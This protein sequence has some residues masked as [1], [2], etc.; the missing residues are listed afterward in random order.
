[1]PTFGSLFAGIGGLDLG[2]ERAGF[3]CRWQVEFDPTCTQVLS[4]H[5]PDVKRFGDVTQVRGEDLEPVDLIVGGWPCQD[6]SLAGRRAGLAGRRSGL[7]FEFMRLVDELSPEWILAENVPGLLSAGCKPKCPGGCVRT[8][9]GAMGSVIGSLADRGYGYAWR[10]LDAQYLGLAQR[11]KRVF[12]VGHLGTPWSGPAQ[13]LFEPESL[14]GDPPSRSASGSQ[15]AAGTA[16]SARGDDRSV[17]EPIVPPVSGTLGG[18]S[19]NRGWSDDLD[20]AGAFVGYPDP[21]HAL[22]APAHGLRYDFES[23]S[24]AYSVYPES[25]QGADLRAVEIQVAPTLTGT[26]EAEATDRGTR[27]VQGLVRRLTPVECERLQGF[28]DGWTATGASGKAISDSKRYK[29][30]G[31]AVASPCAEWIARRL[32]TVMQQV[33]EDFSDDLERAV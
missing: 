8:H 3:E 12:I 14:R 10:V 17:L 23:E 32:S 26:A 13:V 27:I 24:Y 21:S 19:G 15:P 2:L 29:M 1:M 22:S 33:W 20:R 11:R 6:L 7:F 30:I 5:W 4:R 16:G 9:G 18:G 31:N 28:P 25:G